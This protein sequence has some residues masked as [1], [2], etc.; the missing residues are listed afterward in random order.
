[1][2]CC[3]IASPFAATALFGDND[4]DDEEADEEDEWDAKFVAGWVCGI[5]AAVDDELLLA[6][7]DE[8]EDDDDDGSADG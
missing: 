2:R 3:P 4:N 1:L 7:D 8:D 6:A 5:D